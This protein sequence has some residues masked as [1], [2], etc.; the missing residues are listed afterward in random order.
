M[1][2]IGSFKGTGKNIFFIWAKSK[3]F[4]TIPGVLRIMAYTGRL[5]PNLKPFS[6]LRY[7]QGYKGFHF[8]YQ[9]LHEYDKKTSFLGDLVTNTG[10]L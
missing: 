8:I 2:T 1:I 5:C 9:V 3:I 4:Q 7:I 10:Q 6:G